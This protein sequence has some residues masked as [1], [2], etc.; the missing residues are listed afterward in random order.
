MRWEIKSINLA[1]I[2]PNL[3]SVASTAKS[4][5]HLDQTL[6]SFEVL[7]KFVCTFGD[8]LNQLLYLNFRSN[9]ESLQ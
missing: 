7:D 8:R 4:L 6:R 1:S 5:L 3:T 9:N 2:R